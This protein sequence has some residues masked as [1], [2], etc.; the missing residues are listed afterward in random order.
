MLTQSL[1]RIAKACRDMAKTNPLLDCLEGRDTVSVCCARDGLWV[2]IRQAPNAGFD[3][4]IA[5]TEYRVHAYQ[6]AYAGSAWEAITTITQK[7]NRRNS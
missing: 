6:T 3:E 7:L 5:L 4:R 1:Q 2:E